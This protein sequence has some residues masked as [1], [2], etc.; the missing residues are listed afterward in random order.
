MLQTMC[1]GS[2]ERS[3]RGRGGGITAS[4]TLEPDGGVVF[5]SL[6][7][8]EGRGW[9]A[10]APCLG[11]LSSCITFD[12][13]LLFSRWHGVVRGTRRR[14]RIQIHH[15]RFGLHASFPPL[16]G[17]SCDLLITWLTV[18]VHVCSRHSTGRHKYLHAVRTFHD[19]PMAP[20]PCV[21]EL[22]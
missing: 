6:Y 5:P 21:C 16:A 8:V 20:S 14:G 22:G 18:F 10:V 15:A 3:R 12:M 9:K 4:G 19:T 2:G 11:G 17:G 13:G 1:I 7:W